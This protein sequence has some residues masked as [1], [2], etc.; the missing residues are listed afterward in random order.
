MIR[1]FRA[2]ENGLH[3]DPQGDLLDISDPV[4]IPEILVM[5]KATHRAHLNRVRAG[6]SSGLARF[7][8]AL[9]SLRRRWCMRNEAWEI[10]AHTMAEVPTAKSEGASRGFIDDKVRDEIIRAYGSGVD[11]DLIR[12]LTSLTLPTLRKIVQG[13]QH[14]PYELRESD[15]AAWDAQL[16]ATPVNTMADIEA[17]DVYK[18]DER[19]RPRGEAAQ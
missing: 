1:R 5:L 13:Q 14:T 9:L 12:D 10:L 3:E 11:L 16:V 15:V 8:R 17:F 6:Y 4:D 2:D 19:G 18:S 7:Q